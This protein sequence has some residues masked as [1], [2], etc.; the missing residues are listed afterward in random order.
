MTVHY[1]RTEDYNQEPLCHA[2]QNKGA[3]REMGVPGRDAALRSS[4]Q[5]AASCRPPQDSNAKKPA[6]RQTAADGK[7]VAMKAKTNYKEVAKARER[8]S[9]RS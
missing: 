2:S 4:G 5:A 8:M 9:E 6:S 1:E 7:A 3:N